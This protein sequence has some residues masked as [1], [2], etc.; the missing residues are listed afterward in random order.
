M[1]FMKKLILLVLPFFAMTLS[2][3]TIDLNTGAFGSLWTVT[4]VSGAD[5][6]LGLNNTTGAVVLT[7][8]LPFTAN[9]PEIGIY[10]VYRWANPFG[11]AVWVG[12]LATD[13]QFPNGGSIPCGN[14]CGAEP[15]TY[16]YQLVFDASQ[17]GT[18]VLSGF[19]GDN[20]LRVFSVFQANNGW[21][22]SC[23]DSPPGLLCAAGTSSQ[24][25]AST[26]TL[27]LKAGSGGVVTILGTV[28]NVDGFAGRNPSGFILAGSATL[29]DASAVPEPST[30]VML[31]LGGL[32][33][34]FWRR[35]K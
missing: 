12:Q 31:G 33:I 25:T 1:C 8:T 4:Q 24:V 21:L 14:P 20:G 32:A 30:Y 10:P 22:Y 28:Q 23:Q 2:A 29:N 19:T 17:G 9:V 15:A 7:G 26:G 16:I 13:G 34:G 27:T 5:N 11:G 18:M 6:G 35:R 3:S